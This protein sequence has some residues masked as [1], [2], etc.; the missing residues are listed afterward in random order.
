MSEL[1]PFRCEIIAVGSELLTPHFLDTNSLFI[2]K[3]LNNLG[4]ETAFKTI[5]GDNSAD[6]QQC[7]RTAFSRTRLVVAIGGLGP[8][9]DDLT[10]ETL[11]DTLGKGLIYHP[12]ILNAM[13]QRFQRRGLK[14]SPS[15]KK[16]AYIPEGADIL[17]NPN[18]T[19]PGLILEEND[20]IVVLLPGPPKELRSMFTDRVIPRLEKYRQGYSFRRILRITG[21]G[22]SA[23][24][25]EIADLYPDDP[26]ITVTILAAP[27]QIDIHLLAHSEKSTASARKKIMILSKKIEFRLGEQIYSTDGRTLEEVLG[28]QLRENHKTLAVA[29]SCTG[30]LLG[31]RITNVPGSSDY[32][33]QGV[34]SY[35]NQAKQQRLGISAGLI[36]RYGAV[37]SQTAQAMADGIRRTSRADFGLAITGIAGPGGGTPDKPVG[38]VYTALSWDNEVQ[39]EKNDFFGDRETVK[40]RSSQKSL[41]ML[42]IH[43]I[44]KAPKGE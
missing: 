5:V 31:H 7:F 44:H 12:D 41:D 25:S 9:R 33:L 23:I 20:R 38:L 8:T 14:M 43:L 35:S 6:L 28:D 26:E 19:A 40:F 42:R 32:F 2:T 39:V 4:I 24:E 37:S 21:P 11:A 27:G 17:D 3:K 34:Q 36:K 10:R 15:N 13:E 29:E 22:E 30:G 16:Q 18:G 1:S